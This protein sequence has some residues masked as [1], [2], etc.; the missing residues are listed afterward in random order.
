DNDEFSQ[1]IHGT[2]KGVSTRNLE[3][4][5]KNYCKMVSHVVYT[6]KEISMEIQA[7]DGDGAA[8]I[9]IWFKGGYVGK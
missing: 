9:Q 2:Y 4:E 6:A 8:L 3:V 7:R 1:K 5:M